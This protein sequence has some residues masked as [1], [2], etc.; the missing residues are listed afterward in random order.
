MIN[1]DVLKKGA[2]TS[3]KEFHEL[4]TIL[5]ENDSENVYIGINKKALYHLLQDH[6]E[7]HVLFQKHFKEIVGIENGGERS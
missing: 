2:Q 3:A 6:S 1:D 4:V 7:F 5:Q